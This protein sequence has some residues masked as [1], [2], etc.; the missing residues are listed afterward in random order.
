[1]NRVVRGRGPSN[2]GQEARR[3]L[4]RDD[5]MVAT[6]EGANETRKPPVRCWASRRV[7]LPWSI[8]WTRRRAAAVQRERTMEVVCPPR[9]GVR[10]VSAWRGGAKGS[11]S[12]AV[13]RTSGFFGFCIHP[14]VTDPAGRRKQDS[15]Q[16]A[17]RQLL[18]SFGR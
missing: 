14:F 7:D 8:G 18:G 17:S 3:H 10:V 2:V 15:R 4:S 1:M 12:G 11:E 6:P 9:V 13:N 16:R 5:V